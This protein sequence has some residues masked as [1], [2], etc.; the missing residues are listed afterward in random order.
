MAACVSLELKH[1]LVQ[2][3]HGLSKRKRPKGRAADLEAH[4]AEAS[5]LSFVKDKIEAPLLSALSGKAQWRH[6]HAIL[7][8]EGLVLKQRGAGLVIAD[9]RSGL[10]VKASAVNR[11]FS[12]KELAS[13]L[14]A[15]QPGLAGAGAATDAYG[16][17]P[18]HRFNTATLYA[19][20]IDQRRQG[21]EARRNS[22]EAIAAARNETYLAFAKRRAE[23]SRSG[24][25]RVGKSS[26]R[27]ELRRMRSHALAALT[28]KRRKQEEAIQETYFFTWVSYLQARAKGGSQDALRALRASAAAG[29]KTAAAFLTAKDAGGA[30]TIIMRDL[31]PVIRRNGELV[32]HLAD[33]GAVID[34]KLRIR[35]DKASYQAAILALTLTDFIA[36]VQDKDIRAALGTYTIEGALGHLLDA[37][38]DGVEA[39][40]FT[41]F[42]IEEL[43]ALGE[44]NLIPVLLYLFRHFERSLTGAPALRGA[45]RGLAASVA[46][47]AGARS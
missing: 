22:H 44:K 19:A 31:K 3:N 4:A 21:L 46:R 45:W 18:L 32:Y 2:T 1:G 20:Y 27:S 23:V 24:L 42:E 33:G 11:A 47:G 30:K 39:A 12:M 13:R 43:M 29:A 8:S 15:F 6:L 28:A 14:G 36:T 34:E 5:F 16:R 10:A 37:R 7:A 26:R 41:V 17:A 40:A 35:I 9:A 38:S 25:T